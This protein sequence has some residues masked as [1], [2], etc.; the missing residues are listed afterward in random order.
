MASSKFTRGLFLAGIV[1]AAP[2]MSR[3]A[4]AEEAA[5]PNRMF[6]ALDTD[7]DGSLARD[8]VVAQAN[9]LVGAL[10]FRADTDGDGIVSPEEARALEASLPAVSRAFAAM[11]TQMTGEELDALEEQ[12]GA[13]WGAPI[14]AAEARDAAEQAVGAFFDAADLDDDGQLSREELSAEIG[15]L[16]SRVAEAEF[17]M[18][19]VDRTGSLSTAEFQAAL[20]GP[21]RIAF[22]AADADGNGELSREEAREAARLLGDF[23]TREPGTGDD[24]E[25]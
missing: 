5:V 6:A 20:A 13:A 24:E 16:A 22:A 8:E 14:S 18:A 3:G 4:G 2:A 23:L 21:G 7:R 19:D 9:M 1:A 15:D 11:R 25:E 12:V 10:F 17:T